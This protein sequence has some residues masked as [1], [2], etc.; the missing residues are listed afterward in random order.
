MQWYK[1]SDKK[2]PINEEILYCEKEGEEWFLVQ[3]H[4]SPNGKLYPGAYYCNDNDC[5]WTCEDCGCALVVSE[6]SY[7]S[8]VTFP[9]MNDD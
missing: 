3:V 5:R 4:V 9:D 2:P 7:W 8:T 1:F 6:S